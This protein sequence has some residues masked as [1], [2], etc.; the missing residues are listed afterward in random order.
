VT[1]QNH[2]NAPTTWDAGAEQPRAITKNVTD[3][4]LGV[5]IHGHNYLPS[6]MGLSSAQYKANEDCAGTFAA[7]PSEIMTLRAGMFTNNANF[8]LY[9]QVR[10]M[11]HVECFDPIDLSQS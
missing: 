7:N 6:L 10:L 9:W 5:T 11:Y 8:S 2:A 1:P 4:G 3:T